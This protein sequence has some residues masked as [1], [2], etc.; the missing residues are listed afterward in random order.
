MRHWVIQVVSLVWL[1]IAIYTENT[2]SLVV[3]N[4][5]IAAT[6]M[7]LAM[8]YEYRQKVS[9]LDKLEQLLMQEAALQME[10]HP[11]KDARWFAQSV[12]TYFQDLEWRRMGK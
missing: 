2:T 6:M 4:I 5:W 7:S 8:R 1:G 11:S 10:E 3:A 12:H 9:K